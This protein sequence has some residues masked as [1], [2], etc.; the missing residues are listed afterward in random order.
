MIRMARFY[1]ISSYKN[2]EHYFEEMAL[3]GWMVTNINEVYFS[4]KKIEPQKL[5]FNVIAGVSKRFLFGNTSRADKELINLCEEAGWRFVTAQ[6]GFNVFYTDSAKV[7]PLHTDE[8]EEYKQIRKTYLRTDGI[9]SVFFMSLMLLSLFSDNKVPIYSGG[10]IP[11]V[12]FYLT[13]LFMLGFTF[14]YSLPQFILI[15]REGLRIKKGYS[16]TVKD[17]EDARSYWTFGTWF[18]LLYFIILTVFSFSNEVYLFSIGVYLV[19][20]LGA[21]LYH[22]MMNVKN[23]F[24]GVGLSIIIAFTV[25]IGGGYYLKYNLK[26]EVVDS[27]IENP[28]FSVKGNI[29]V[30]SENVFSSFLCDKCYTTYEKSDGARYTIT[31]IQTDKNWFYNE[32]LKDMIKEHAFD[33][34]KIIEGVKTYCNE[35]QSNQ[36]GYSLLFVGDGTLLHIYVHFDSFEY[37]SEDLGNIINSFN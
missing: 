36:I 22:L 26:D 6:K 16:K 24:I 5:R 21:L 27:I 14:I 12:T 34:Y 7:A 37:I 31:F 8:V 30:T 19:F 32:S 35:V 11:F 20:V 10:G 18:I 25:M 29:E 9:F 15:V 4:F 3:K 23:S 28:Y 33:D 2:M 13:S 17:Y 1:S